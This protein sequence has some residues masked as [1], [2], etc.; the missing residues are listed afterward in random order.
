ML[1]AAYET[2]QTFRLQKHG[3]LAAYRNFQK[4]SAPGFT[5]VHLPNTA[6][7]LRKG[8]AL[9][10]QVPETTEVL[11]RNRGMQMVHPNIL[12]GPQVNIPPS[13]FALKPRKEQASTLFGW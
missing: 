4:L 6:Q 9:L 1:K 2:L 13:Q 10:Q 3:A 5:G 11:A 7:L 12:N 8:K